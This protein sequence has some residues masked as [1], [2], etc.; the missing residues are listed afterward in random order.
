MDLFSATGGQ[1]LGSMLEAFKATD[2]G[3]AILEKITGP[4]DSEENKEKEE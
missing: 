4:T 2:A 3:Q 1:A